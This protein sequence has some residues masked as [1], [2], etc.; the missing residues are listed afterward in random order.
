M[1]LFQITSVDLDGFTG[2]EYHPSRSDVGLVVVPL[3]LAT[4]VLREDA[5]EPLP[6]PVRVAGATASLAA[7]QRAIDE[8]I[9][10]DPALAQASRAEAD[11][12][13][14]LQVWTCLTRDGRLLELMEHEIEPFTEVRP[15]GARA[16]GAR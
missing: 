14:L 11:A 3:G 8:A 12:P 6:A 10:A 9:G 2:R 1:R 7:A 4:F 16:G 5:I 15:L 13:A